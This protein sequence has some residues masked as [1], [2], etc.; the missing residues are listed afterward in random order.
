MQ[1]YRDERG[2]GPYSPD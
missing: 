1:A 2:E